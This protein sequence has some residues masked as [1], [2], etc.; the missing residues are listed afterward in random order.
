M[1][2]IKSKISAQLIKDLANGLEIGGFAL[3]YREG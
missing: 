1:L 3:A 2:N